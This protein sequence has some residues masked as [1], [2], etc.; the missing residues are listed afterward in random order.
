VKDDKGRF[1]FQKGPIVYCLEG[2]D[3][4]DSAV[5]NIVVDKNA[6]V[7]ETFNQNLLNGVL[8]LTTKGTSTRR[9]LNS[10]VL[11]KTE[12]EVKAIPYYEWN[13][14]GADEMEVWI[15]YVD[16]VALP[17]PAPTIA[18]KSKVSS[19]LN[20]PRME[21]TLNDQYDPQNSND[22]S[23]GFLH[24]WPKKNTTEWVQYDF[25]NEYIVSESSI[26]WFDDGPDGG[27][28][29]PASWKLFYKDGNNWVPVKNLT[30]FEVSKDKYNIIKFEPV[31][32]KALRLEVKLPEEF[33]AGIHEWSVK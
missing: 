13:N 10:D 12:H 33:A 3:N 19:S 18:T 32:T 11:L 6:T 5:L 14:R 31:K 9:Q 16:S 24:W 29:I 2:V 27:C 21:K 26:Y 20:N 30:P 23:G 8:V 22:H 25:D 28:R 17:K 4:A 1:A 7:K 15:P